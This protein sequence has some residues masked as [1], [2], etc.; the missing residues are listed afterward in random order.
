VSKCNLE[1]LSCMLALIRSR[2]RL[3]IARVALLACLA[4]SL[5]SCATK[6]APLIA[7]PNATHNETAL[8]WN[9]QQKWETEGQ[10]AAL[11]QGRR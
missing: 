11:T 10:A 2:T 1:I 4:A 9:Q 6:D 5:A 7:D 3:E 8:P